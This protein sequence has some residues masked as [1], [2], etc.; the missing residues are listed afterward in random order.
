MLYLLHQPPST[1][2]ITVTTDTAFNMT[3]LEAPPPLILYTYIPAVLAR[4]V[5][6]F[7]STMW[8]SRKSVLLPRARFM[9]AAKSII[10]EFRMGNMAWWKPDNASGIATTTYFS[11]SSPR[12]LKEG[13][14]EGGEGGYQGNTESRKEGTKA[15]YQGK[16]S[17]KNIKERHQGKMSR[18]IPRKDMKE[19]RNQ[20]KI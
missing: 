11:R 18:K 3:N 7:P 5:F 15:R 6:C 2:N 17:R 10:D 1:A 9:T 16:L 4:S 20:G 12:Y 13:G 14:R 8:L 19:G